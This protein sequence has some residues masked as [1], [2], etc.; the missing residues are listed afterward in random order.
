MPVRDF[1]R[2]NAA[3]LAAGF[4]LSFTSSYGQTYFISVFA[5]EIRGEFGLSHGAWGGLY[6][7]GT[8]ASALL[9]VWAGLLTDRFRARQLGIF[10]AAIL[11]CACLAMSVVPNVVALVGVIFLLRFSGQGMMSQL[12]NVSMARW[13]VASRGLALSISSMGFAVGQ[14]ALPVAFVALLAVFDWRVLWLVAAALVVV[15]F[16]VIYRLLKLERTPQSLASEGESVTGMNNRHWTRVE[17]AR[18]WLFWL[19]IPVIIGPPAWGTAL[20]FQQVHLAE[21]K[22]WRLVEFVSLLP[23]FTVASVSMTLA[24]GW[25]IDRFGTGRLMPFFPLP[26]AAGFLALSFAQTLPAAGLGMVLVGIG[27]GMQATLPAAFWAEFYGTRHLGGL[28]A[29]SMALMVLASAVGPG[30]TGALIDAGY[31]FP[32]QMLGIVAYYLVAGGLAAIGAAWARPLLTT[33]AEVDVVRP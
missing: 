15:T 27:S 13:F 28:K 24:S 4:L 30:L 22:G 20:F 10:V 9:M 29:L 32:E 17:A 12:A 8:T 31:D 3:F 23:F 21:V 19:A 2:R 18:H 16:P 1:I 5:G 33:P 7:L 14:A 26:F 25:A 11:T 6:T